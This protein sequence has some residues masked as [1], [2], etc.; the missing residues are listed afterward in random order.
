MIYDGGMTWGGE[1]PGS[2]LLEEEDQ[3]IYFIFF[4]IEFQF[5][6]IPYF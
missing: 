2:G 1:T 3:N 5:H 6:F 4:Q